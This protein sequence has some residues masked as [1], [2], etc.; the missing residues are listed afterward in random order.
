M[1]QTKSILHQQPNRTILIADMV[2]MFPF[3]P[4]ETITNYVDFWLSMHHKLQDYDIQ[5]LIQALKRLE[6]P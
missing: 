6:N 3:L 1:G 4:K 2:D 5:Y